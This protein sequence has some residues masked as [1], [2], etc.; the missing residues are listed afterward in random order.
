MADTDGKEYCTVQSAFQIEDGL[1]WFMDIEMECG[2]R[3][4]W[5]EVDLPEFCPCCGKKLG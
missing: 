1:G 5:S 3:Y 4:T 2:G